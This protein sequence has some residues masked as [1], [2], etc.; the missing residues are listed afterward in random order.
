MFLGLQRRHMR[1]TIFGILG[2]TNSIPP[3]FKT[4]EQT[5]CLALFFKELWYNPRIMP[6]ISELG[7]G[8]Q[9]DQ[10]FPISSEKF[11]TPE[12]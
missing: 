8:Q 6:A 1:G 7:Q 2:L 4:P 5:S 12:H 9:P 10:G 11:F 3:L